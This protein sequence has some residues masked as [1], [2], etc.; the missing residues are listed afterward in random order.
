MY[1]SQLRAESSADCGALG[2]SPSAARRNVA[3]ACSSIEGMSSRSGKSRFAISRTAL[4]RMSA[5]SA[6]VVSRIT[7]RQVLRR[8][9]RCRRRSKA[10]LSA[11]TA[12]C[13]PS[14]TREARNSDVDSGGRTG[15]S[16]RRRIKDGSR[17]VEA[18][19]RPRSS[20]RRTASYRVPATSTRGT[21]VSWSSSGAAAAPPEV[22]PA[23]SR[24]SAASPF[25]LSPSGA[26]EGSAPAAGQAVS[27][28]VPASPASPA[29]GAAPSFLAA[30]SCATSA[31][32]GVSSAGSVCIGSPCVPSSFPRSFSTSIGSAAAASAVPSALSEAKL[33]PFSC[34]SFPVG[35]PAASRSSS[36]VGSPRCSSSC[37][38][39]SGKGSPSC[40]SSCVAC[41]APEASPPPA[42]SALPS[43][44]GSGRRASPIRASCT[45]SCSLFGGSPRAAFSS[46]PSSAAC[47]SSNTCDVSPLV[48]PTAGASPSWVSRPDPSGA[49]SALP[50]P[51]DRAPPGGSPAVS[52]PLLASPP[53]PRSWSGGSEV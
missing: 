21:S 44:D 15:A 45:A 28:S 18:S 17:G 40:G 43:C 27:A 53:S 31:A 25:P 11:A 19:L 2:S 30:A 1:S 14:A 34:V 51:P 39:P 52:P 32:E 46:P 38:A 24:P 13:P 26:A 3:A 6:S 12:H 5:S 37:G 41:A 42:S 9:G 49:A 23:P 22:A 36:G 8:P 29:P 50:S 35:S 33:L 4:L 16:C 48:S 10:A 47:C 7:R 20:R